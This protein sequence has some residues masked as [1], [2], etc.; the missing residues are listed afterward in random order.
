MKELKKGDYVLATKWNDGDPYDHWVVGFLDRVTG[1]AVPRYMIV[2]ND[3]N[4]MRGN[5]FSRAKKISQERGDLL[6]KLGRKNMIVCHSIWHW[7]RI[8]MKRLEGM[9]AE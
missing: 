7:A 9:L 4:Q 6:L 8:S 2:D 3:G 5:G 1:D